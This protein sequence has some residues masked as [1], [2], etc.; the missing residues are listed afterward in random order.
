MSGGRVAT[1]EPALRAE[2]E[3]FYK[4]ELGREVRMGTDEELVWAREQG[5]IVGACRLF[6]AGGR[7]VLRTMVVAAGRRGQG[8]GRSLLRTASERIG[9]RECYCFPWT[10]LERFYG[11]IGF[12][13][14]DRQAVPAELLEYLGP[15]CMPTRR[16]VRG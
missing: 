10:H 11:E 2:I 14:I 6:P 16:E 13:P 12:R 8:I 4:R 1:V 15:G 5:V 9:E 3:A 7:L